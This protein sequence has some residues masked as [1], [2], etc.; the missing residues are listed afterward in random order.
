MTSENI[1]NVLK[2]RNTI[3]NDFFGGWNADDL[4]LLDK[5]HFK[6]EGIQGYITDYYGVR[7]SVD[8]VPWAAGLSGAVITDPPIPDDGVRAETIEYYALH[9]AINNSMG[10]G[11]TAIELGASYGPWVCAAGV[12]SK[13]IGKKRINLIAVEASGYFQKMIADNFTINNLYSNNQGIRINAK[14]IHG[15]V[16][17]KPGVIYFPKVISAWENG[18][19]TTSEIVKVDYIGREVEHEEVPALTLNQL[20][21][22]LPVVDFLHC[23]IQGAELEVLTH[24]ASLLTVKHLFIGT[25]SRYI[26]GVLIDCFHKHGW[27]L[28]RERPAA[29]V[30][31]PERHS[32]VGMTVRDGGQYWINSGLFASE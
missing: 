26:E 21:S 5:Y 11:F 31:I 27:Q 10:D 16:S 4:S 6:E 19:Q 14:A 22:D 29:F 28:L 9:H 23:D 17:I 2:A 30:H 8:C 7:T 3:P 18:G 12:I 1:E 15:A 24:G 25:H 32:V 13:R 20:L